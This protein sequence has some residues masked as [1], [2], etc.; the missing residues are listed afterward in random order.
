[1]ADFSHR[2]RRVHREVNRALYATTG[3]SLALIAL[4][5]VVSLPLVGI[6]AVVALGIVGLVYV[7]WADRFLEEYANDLRAAREGSPRGSFVRAEMASPIGLDRDSRSPVSVSPH[8]RRRTHLTDADVARSPDGP[9][10]DRQ[11]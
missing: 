6:G 5:L 3:T 9:K 8:S 1:M 11:D 7:V 2:D 10:G 4:A